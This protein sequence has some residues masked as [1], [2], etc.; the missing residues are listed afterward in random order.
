MTHRK[1]RIAWSVV[2]GMGAVLLVAFWV[3]SY[4]VH[5]FY[6]GWF[7]P[8]GFVQIDSDYGRLRLIAIDET[9]PRNSQ[10]ECESRDA[11]GTDGQWRW[12]FALERQ[13]RWR[14]LAIV[15]DWLAFGLATVASALPWTNWWKRFSV[16]FLLIVMTLVAVVLGVFA[17]R[18]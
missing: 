15:P 14:L 3:R 17:W 12:Y 6:Y 4:W 1:L 9:A 5:D 16:R 11:V 8:T 13:P 18:H 2:W 7:H 10:W